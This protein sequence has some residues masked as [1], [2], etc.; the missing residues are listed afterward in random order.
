LSGCTPVAA[1]IIALGNDMILNI[2]YAI[3]NKR[4]HLCCQCMIITHVFHSSYGGKTWIGKKHIDSQI[5]WYY[6]V[7]TT[8]LFYLTHMCELCDSPQH[9]HLGWK[10]LGLGVF[11]KMLVAVSNQQETGLDPSISLDLPTD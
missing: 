8:S 9:S 5:L 4:G 10:E 7:A 11:S 3:S 6:P 2:K 1:Q